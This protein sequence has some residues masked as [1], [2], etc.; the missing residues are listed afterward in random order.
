MPIGASD[1][2]Q[3]RVLVGAVTLRSLERKGL[4]PTNNH[5][6][7]ASVS[8]TDLTSVRS[9]SHSL[10][11]MTERIHVFIASRPGSLPGSLLDSNLSLGPAL[12]RPMVLSNF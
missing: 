10:T 11:R 3:A 5:V 7:L 8:T 2:N 12:Q 9:E 6:S 1:V 4:I